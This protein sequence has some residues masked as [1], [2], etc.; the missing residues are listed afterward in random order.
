MPTQEYQAAW[1][2]YQEAVEGLY[3]TTEQ[4]TIERG[5]SDTIAEAPDLEARA[6]A[7]VEGSQALGDAIAAR[8]QSPDPDERELAEMQLLA[9]AAS[10][11]AVASDLARLAEDGEQDAVQERGSAM[12]A[13]ISELMVVLNASRVGGLSGLMHKEFAAFRSGGVTE[14]T[15]ARKELQKTMEGALTDIEDDAA[16]A[17]QAAINAL[18]EIPLPPLKAAAGIALHELLDKMGD[19]VSSLVRKA[20]QLVVQA[21][22]KI[23]KALGKSAQEEARRQAAAWIENLKGGEVFSSLLSKLYESERIRQDITARISGSSASLSADLFNTTGQKAGELAA[24]FRKQ[25]E[26]MLRVIQGLA[27]ARGW[28]MT[29]QPWGTLA[30][31]TAYVASIGYIVYLGGDYVDWFRTGAS[32]RLDFVPGLRAIVRQTIPEPTP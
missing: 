27:W 21:I 31:T 18:L 12:S 30:L 16:K 4:K 23:C 24:K 10:D 2:A 5:G 9:A 22:D 26:I 3:R 19:A 28:I 17:G 7:V 32:E 25:K 1:T 13:D 14:P 8:Q 20:T 29:L 11:L 15:E 6:Q